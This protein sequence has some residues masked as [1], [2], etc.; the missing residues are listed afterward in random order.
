MGD[1][2]DRQID[3]FIKRLS[4]RFEAS[5]DECEF[6]DCFNEFVKESI[7]GGMKD[8]KNII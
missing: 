3:E 6:E 2:I 8:K 5:E 7:E 1:N 4:E